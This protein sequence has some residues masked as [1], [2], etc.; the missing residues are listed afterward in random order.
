MVAGSDRDDS[1]GWRVERACAAAW[2]AGRRVT[3]G[4]WC[5]QHSG[6]GTR[7]INSASA[8]APVPLDPDTLEAI[9]RCYTGAGLPAI[10]RLTSLAP[11]SSALLDAADYLP[12]EGS[13]ATLLHDLTGDTGDDAGVRIDAIPS[14][15]WRAARRALSRS[16][17]QGAEDHLAPIARLA[18]PAG[19]AS[20]AIE[21]RIVSLAF[22]ACHDGI[23]VIEA[24][25]T[26]PAARR[27]GFAGRVVGALLGWARSQRA[28]AMALQVAHDNRAARALYRGLGFDRHLY[29]YHYR[30]RAICPN[31]A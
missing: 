13:S 12:A 26:D 14:D 16:A 10:V 20:L 19:F 1:W 3:V 28:E 29:D 25:A 17:G 8:L 7:R 27:R 23:A 18:I 30:R 9:E 5:V 2:P 4:Q 6:G 31:F 15:A 22:A 24:V 21:G 11:D